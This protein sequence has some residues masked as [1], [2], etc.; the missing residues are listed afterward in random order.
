MPTTLSNGVV[1][2]SNDLEP[3]DLY[4]VATRLGE[5]TNEALE[6]PYV[7]LT[8]SAGTVLTPGTYTKLTLATTVH[9]DSSA[10]SVASSVVTILEDGIYD[11]GANGRIGNVTSDQKALKIVAS[12][13][14]GAET[15]V[16]N[17]FA[18]TAAP[19]A[20]HVTYAA[21]TTVQVQGLSQSAATSD[22]GARLLI[23][24]VR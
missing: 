21:G 1:V 14:S 6:V 4:G 11:I 5:S 10:F 13:G 3:A 9:L 22:T 17:V 2:P 23:R 16:D 15:R 12:A 19:S 7:E 8:A 20:L 24:K 18:L